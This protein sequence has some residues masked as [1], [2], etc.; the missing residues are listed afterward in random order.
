[1]ILGLV[2]KSI[3]TYKKQITDLANRETANLLLV[4]F[5][6]AGP[7][8][9]LRIIAFSEDSFTIRLFNL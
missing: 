4:I 6:L 9:D 1:M 7:T 8:T 2:G 3:K 5:S